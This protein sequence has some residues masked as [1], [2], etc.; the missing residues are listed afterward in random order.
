[1]L[2]NTL[3]PA[4]VTLLKQQHPALFSLQRRYI[5]RIATIGIV[6]VLYYL[7]F[8]NFLVSTGLHLFTESNKLAVI[9]YV[10]LSGMILLTGHLNITLAKFLLPWRSCLPVP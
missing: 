3:S 6:I 2:M 8:F 7:L 4:D 10:C 5:G 9:F 1:M